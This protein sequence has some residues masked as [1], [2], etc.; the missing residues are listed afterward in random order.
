MRTNSF[1]HD[2]SDGWSFWKIDQDVM[3]DDDQGSSGNTTSNA[4]LDSNSTSTTGS[5]N[6]SSDDNSTSNATTLNGTQLL[7]KN[8]N[9][10]IYLKRVKNVKKTSVLSESEALESQDV[11]EKVLLLRNASNPKVWFTGDQNQAILLA[12]EAPTENEVGNSLF[13][14]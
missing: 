13:M 10:G 6:S 7:N 3:T 14:I 4:T 9:Y 8:N 11:V 5:T 1:L 12:Y 2:F